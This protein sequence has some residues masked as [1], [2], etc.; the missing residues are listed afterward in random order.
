M[1]E[2]W[3]WIPIEVTPEYPNRRVAIMDSLHCLV[4]WSMGGYGFAFWYGD[5]WDNITAGG[6]KVTHYLPLR[7]IPFIETEPPPQEGE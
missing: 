2:Q 5:R 4:K 1:S 3:G 7:D 6:N